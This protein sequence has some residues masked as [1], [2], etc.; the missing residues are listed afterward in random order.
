MD[1]Q[2]IRTIQK[3]QLGTSLTRIPDWDHINNILKNNNFTFE[4]K[5]P[6]F[7][8]KAKAAVGL[9]NTGVNKFAG[10]FS[11]DTLQNGAHSLSVYAGNKAGDYSFANSGTGKTIEA[12]KS[13]LPP[14]LR[15]YTDVM[16]LGLNTVD[17]TL[18]STTKQF[19]VDNQVLENLGAGYSGATND[20]LRAKDVA[21][22]KVGL[23]RTIGGKTGRLNNQIDDASNEYNVMAQIN[24]N[25][26]DQNQMVADTTQLYH[27]NYQ[28]Q[29]NGNLNPRAY[30]SAYGEDG[31]KLKRLKKIDFRKSGGNLSLKINPDNKG[32][33]WQPIITYIEKPVEEPIEEPIEKFQKGGKQKDF[34][35]THFLDT[36][37]ENLRNEDPEYNMYRYWELNDKPKDF[38]EGVQKGLFTFE[39]NLWH[40][41]SV[42]YNKEADEYEFV[43][44]PKH[45]TVQYEITEYNSPE[46]AKFREEYELDQSSDVWK[47]KRR[48][49]KHEEGD[50]FKN[51]KDV[52]DFYKD[53]DLSNINFIIDNNPRTEGNN[54]YIKNDE[55][56]VHELWHY[57]SQNQ[58]NESYK[59]WYDNLNDEKISG[60]GGDLQF[61]KRTGDPSEFYNPSELESRIKAAK[62][63]TKDQNY[64][65][66]FFQNLRK[67]ENQY[68][69]NMRDLLHMFNDDNLVKIFNLNSTSK[70]EE[71]GVIQQNI[72]PEGALHA[73]KN[74]IETDLEITNKGIPVVTNE[75]DQTAEIEKNEIILRLEVTQK[76]EELC[77][78]GSDSAAIEA[79]D[80]LVNEILFNTKDMTG[81]IETT[82]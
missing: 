16:T 35:Y 63:K 40:S 53:Y 12:V 37:P 15:T 76:L 74:N 24:S 23:I 78:D 52:V 66:E 5:N 1:L 77:K 19:S 21:G 59:E 51:Y 47:Y 22:K 60:F 79:G 80:L 68:G 67:N 36:L 20:I 72:I 82:E 50:K 49:Q 46:K 9:F 7:E 6:T 69:Y 39:D 27:L 42:A 54:L 81:L 41:G 4:N 57:L 28:N 48:T 75:G 26:R 3:G 65:K 11:E 33:E 45:P 43:K 70:Y 71:G 58:P 25:V 56:A 2:K 18:A 44:S 34:T 38:L 62:Y 73:R 8:D 32:I 29:I 14:G 17:G 61:V 31:M 10:K 64:T 13:V 55:D 30:M